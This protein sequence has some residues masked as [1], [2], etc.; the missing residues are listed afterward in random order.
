MYGSFHYGLKS[1]FYG[2]FAQLPW[3]LVVTAIV[4]FP[5][6][7]CAESST[8]ILLIQLTIYW[9]LVISIALLLKDL[10]MQRYLLEFSIQGRGISIYKNA[11]TTI[12]YAW[13]QLR[14]IKSIGKKELKYYRTLDANGVLLKFEDGF[15]LP[16]FERVSNYQKFSAILKKIVV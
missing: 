5:V 8:R 6:V 9:A 7:Y 14:A 16:V 4:L 11:D 2:L 15:E 10:Y 12:D 3:S 13:E 1:R